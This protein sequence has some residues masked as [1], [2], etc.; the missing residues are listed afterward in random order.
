MDDVSTDITPE[1]LCDVFTRS[2]QI[3]SYS[4]QGQLLL[5][6]SMLNL[7]S[8]LNIKRNS[9]AS[10]GTVLWNSLSTSTRKLSRKQFKEKIHNAVLKILA[11][12]D[13]YIDTAT[14]LQRTRGL[15]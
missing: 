14:L 12:E 2:R 8:R 5:E 10:F 7:S 9:V 3:H 11:A 13:N 15:Q 1:N 6:I 4:T